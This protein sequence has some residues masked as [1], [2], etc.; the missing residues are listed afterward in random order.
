M[1]ILGIDPGSIRIGFGVIEKKGGS[2]THI[3]SG[4]VIILR[5]SPLNS[6]ERGLTELLEKERPQLVGIEKLFFA[7]NRKTA[8]KVAE[9]RGVIMNTVLKS[10]VPLVEV[11]PSEVKLALT[12]SGRA[13]KKAVF[14]MVKIFLGLKTGPVLDDASDA[15]AIAIAVSNK[16]QG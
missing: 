3:N 14:K 12:G 13:S 7:K 6:L 8:L 1:T 9:S 4:I 10:G 16:Q 2:L 15:L 5:E 11:A